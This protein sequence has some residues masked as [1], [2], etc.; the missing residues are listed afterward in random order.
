MIS[1]GWNWVSPI[2]SY[3]LN[4]LYD[5]QYWLELG[6]SYCFSWSK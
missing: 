4:K 1:T 5:D 6:Q 2:A 3:R